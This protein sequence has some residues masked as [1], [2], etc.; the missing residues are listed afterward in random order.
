MR[1]NRCKFRIGCLLM[2][3]FFCVSLSA[4][5]NDQDDKFDAIVSAQ[6][7]ANEQAQSFPSTA[8]KSEETPSQAPEA[9][10]K[11][12]SGELR[13][14]LPMRDAG[15]VQRS[16]EFKEL[17]PDVKITF[18]CIVDDISAGIPGDYTTRYIQKTVTELSGGD[19]ADIVDLGFV[20]FYKYGAT[21]L[22]E[23]L[24]VLMAEDPAFDREDL[25]TNILDALEDKE[26]KLYALPAT[27][28][29][30]VMI[31]NDYIMY[32]LDMDVE[33]AFKEGAD[34]RDLIDLYWQAV[35]AGAIRPGDKAGGCFFAAGQNK[36]FFEGYVFPRFLDEK[37]GEAHFETPEFIEYLKMT[38]GLPFEKTVAQGGTYPYDWPNF[39][40]DDY[41]CQQLP[42]MPTHLGNIEHNSLAGSTGAIF[43]K[44]RDGDIP[45][46]AA[47]LLAI[48]KG[49]DKELAWEFL[50][51][52]IEEKEFP[53][54]LD[55]YNPNIMLQYFGPYNYAVPINRNN[56]QKLYGAAFSPNLAEKFDA[57]QQTLNRRV[58]NST[59]LMENL[60]DILISYYDNHIISA[61]ECAKQLQERAWI[62]L[63]E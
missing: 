38:D 35:D 48:P 14:S 17:Y 16:K 32:E 47:S 2:A 30:N 28:R 40:T 11:Q 52:V 6:K 33:E 7:A 18:D 61:E 46:T 5:Q 39:G 3:M 8:Q 50:K 31:L 59:E 23:D 29:F 37:A 53:E 55:I 10:K 27:F 19:A 34:Y 43:Y 51:F 13:I 4:C 44:G 54:D 63:N 42:A 56:Y 57:Y 62:Y 21:G 20:S 15:L 22:F 24:N 25:Y 58:G 60:Q 1:R 9:E 36:N 45:F 41:F 12:L 26:G 49:A